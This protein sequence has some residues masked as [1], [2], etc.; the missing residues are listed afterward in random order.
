MFVVSF[1]DSLEESRLL[2]LRFESA[3]LDRLDGELVELDELL[4]DDELPELFDDDDSESESDS[5]ELLESSVAFFLFFFCSLRPPQCSNPFCSWAA[6]V[7]Y[8]G[9]PLGT[10]ESGARF[11][12]TTGAASTLRRAFRF[13]GFFAA[14]GCFANNKQSTL[15]PRTLR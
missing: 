3:E 10:S 2:T 8:K 9:Q 13:L 12:D 6:S 14:G 11:L 4:E 15:T 7:V 5:E 1:V